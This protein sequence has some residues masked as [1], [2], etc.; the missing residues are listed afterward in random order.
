[1]NLA[2]SCTARSEPQRIDLF[3]R[4]RQKAQFLASS[5]MNWHRAAYR[6]STVSIKSAT[7]GLCAEKLDSDGGLILEMLSTPFRPFWQNKLPHPVAPSNRLIPQARRCDKAPEMSQIWRP[8]AKH[9]PCAHPESRANPTRGLLAR[10]LRL[11]F[12]T[13]GAGPGARPQRAPHPWPPISPN[14]EL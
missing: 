7:I 9:P 13:N 2:R 3:Q 8:V 5:C 1:M 4:W 6:S 11:P 10:S 12:P 14:I